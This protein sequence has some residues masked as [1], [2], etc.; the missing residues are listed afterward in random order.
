MNETPI[1]TEPQSSDG[2]AVSVGTKRRN[3]LPWWLWALIVAI[4]V[5]MLALVAIPILTANKPNV[6]PS[7]SPTPSITATQAP[8]PSNTASPTPTPTDVGQ[9]TFDSDMFN[10]MSDV[11][12]SQNTAVLDQ[13]GTFSNPVHVVAANSGQ[14]SN[15]TPTN[16]VAAMSFMFTPM[17]PNPWDLA[18]SDSVLASYRSGPFGQYFPE[19]AIVARSSDGHVFSFIGHDKTVTTMFMSV[20]DDYLK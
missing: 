2:S 17:D 12:N 8:T 6:T 14:D 20:S 19:G 18:L 9:G 16:A 13:G 5:G 10:Y 4:V 11:L 7:V 3:T 1:G 15:L